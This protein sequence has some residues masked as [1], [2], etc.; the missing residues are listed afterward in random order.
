MIFPFL[1]AGLSLAWGAASF[2]QRP[3]SALMNSQAMPLA[4]SPAA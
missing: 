2:N 3:S 4:T 1:I